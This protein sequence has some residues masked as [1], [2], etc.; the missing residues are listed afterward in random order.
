MLIG[1]L[2]SHMDN[3][4]G[5]VVVVLVVDQG[6]IEKVPEVGSWLVWV[7]TNAEQ[8][9]VVEQTGVAAGIVGCNQSSGC[10]LRGVQDGH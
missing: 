7:G 10:L 4:S 8:E 6:G 2:V 1:A 5:V 9:V 3:C